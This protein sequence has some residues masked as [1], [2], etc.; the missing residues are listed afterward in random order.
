VSSPLLEIPRELAATGVRRAVRGVL[1]TL[2]PPVD[3]PGLDPD[4]ARVA[5]LFDLAGQHQQPVAA[6][7]LSYEVDAL[8]WQARLPDGVT[9]SER[10]VAVPA[11]PSG[12][13]R[14]LR[15]R[16]YTPRHLRGDTAA[17]TS[18]LVHVHGG[19]FAIGS[20][21]THDAVCRRLAAGAGV[22][23]QAVEYRLAPEHPFPAGLTDVAAVWSALHREWVRRGGDP[24]RLGIGG[25]SA[26]GHAAATVADEAAAPTLGLDVPMPGFCWLVYPGVRMRDVAEVMPGLL[27][28]GG[29]LNGPMVVRFA[30][31]H[32]PDVADRD[33]PALNPVDQP[34]EVLAQ[35]PPTW[36]QTVG[37]DP[38]EAQGIEYVERL[39]DAGV[40]VDHDHD[41]TMAHGYISMTGISEGAATALGRGIAGLRRLT[42]P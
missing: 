37:F 19:G 1:R 31:L 12:P 6:L 7:R 26:G 13:A 11:D 36:L 38:L 8:A 25:D 2:V 21:R 3:T 33:A 15:V 20:L 23:V 28:E 9:T 40:E 5:R 34:A 22:L 41:P 10:W 4:L 24:A 35:H 27:P 32:V 16:T 14:H 29:L 42:A 39:R 18:C 30:D 17:D